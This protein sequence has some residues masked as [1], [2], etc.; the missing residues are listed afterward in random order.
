MT[1]SCRRPASGMDYSQQLLPPG[2]V[3]GCRTTRPAY[4]GFRG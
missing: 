2:A 4:Q 3:D 1:D